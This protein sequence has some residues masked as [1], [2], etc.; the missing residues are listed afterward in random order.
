MWDL[1]DEDSLYLH[2]NP[3]SIARGAV[4]DSGPTAG[5]RSA[6]I[7]PAKITGPAGLRLSKIS[8][9]KSSVSLKLSVHTSRSSRK[10]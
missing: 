1:E 4:D 7:S 2:S 9:K 5:P 10:V 8:C 3:T 6:F